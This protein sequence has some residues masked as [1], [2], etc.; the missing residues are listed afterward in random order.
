MPTDNPHVLYIDDDPDARGMMQ[1]MLH[2]ANDSY[3]I[4]A[5]SDV[6]KITA[7]IGG[8]DVD[9]Y[10]LDYRLPEMSGIELCRLIRRTDRRTPVL[11]YSGMARAADREKALAAGAAEY[12]VKPGDLEKLTETVE[13]L[14]SQENRRSISASTSPGFTAH[15]TIY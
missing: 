14:L 2:L 11:F 3:R 8:G 4:S 9:L 6:Q 5:V 7:L 13:R 1:V 10:I 15:D 12:L